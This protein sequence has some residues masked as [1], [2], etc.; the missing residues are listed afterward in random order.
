MKAMKSL[1]VMLV[2]LS[3]L[4]A[5][6]TALANGKYRHG[7]YNYGTYHHGQNVYVGRHVYRNPVVPRHGWGYGP[8]YPYRVYAPPVYRGYYAP[9][10]VPDAYAPVYGPRW[11]FG[12]SFGW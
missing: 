12:L 11:S 10:A 5:A 7:G 1:I 3:L 4:L 6:N 8:A 9:Y 2:G